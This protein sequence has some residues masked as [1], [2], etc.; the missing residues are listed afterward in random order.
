VCLSQPLLYHEVAFLLRILRFT[1]D[2]ISHAY[3]IENLADI[4]AA[5][6][7]GAWSTVQKAVL[8]KLSSE[9]WSLET[10]RQTLTT[11]RVHVE[12]R[13]RDVIDHWLD[14]LGA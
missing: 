13:N 2:E 1:I 4:L 6:H 11:K 14:E 3:H 9:D 8:N 7:P 12:N 5:T 10:P